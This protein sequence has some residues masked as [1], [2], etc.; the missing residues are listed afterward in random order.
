MK[1]TSKKNKKSISLKYIYTESIEKLNKAYDI[2]FGETFKDIPTKSTPNLINDNPEQFMSLY[3]YYKIQYPKD[4]EIFRNACTTDSYTKEPKDKL[5]F[6]QDLN[7][8]I[9]DKHPLLRKKHFMYF[10]VIHSAFLMTVHKHF[11]DKYE[12]FKIMNKGLIFE[13]GLTNTFMYPW[14]VLNRLEIFFDKELFGDCLGRAMSDMM[15][16]YRFCE[17]IPRDFMDKFIEDQDLNNSKT[18]YGKEWKGIATKEW[19]QVI[20]SIC[21]K[22]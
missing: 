12:K 14:D 9:R 8:L 21:P 19:F 2:L 6:V 15:T 1:N 4:L 11:N 22:F 7:F 16:D 20:K 3:D 18:P 17:I 5:F 10:L 13:Y